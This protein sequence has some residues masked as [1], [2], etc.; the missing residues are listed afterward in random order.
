MVYR[1][2]ARQPKGL[3]PKNKV[4]SSFNDRE[5]FRIWLIYRMYG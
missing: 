3:R 5:L 1:R 4:R 2:L